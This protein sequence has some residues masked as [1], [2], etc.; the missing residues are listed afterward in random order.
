MLVGVTGLKWDSD[1]L[2]L[3]YLPFTFKTVL[4]GILKGPG[5]FVSHFL[6]FQRCFI[7]SGSTIGEP[8]HFSLI[9]L[10]TS[11]SFRIRS[12]MDPFL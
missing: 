5:I 10:S 3:I 4:C 1:E 7:W 11:F 2:V 6:R 12:G 9:G 8:T